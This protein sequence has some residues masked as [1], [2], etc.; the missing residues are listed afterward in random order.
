M[1]APGIFLLTIPRPMIVTSTNAETNVV[2]M[3]PSVGMSFTLSTNFSMVVP[4]CPGTPNI[5]PN[6]PIATWMPTPV[7]N[8]IRTLRERKSA[9]KPNFTIRAMIKM[10]P[11]MMAVH[12]ASATYC[13]DAIGARPASPAAM[14]A[15]LAESA[16]TTR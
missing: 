14:I 4:D 15:A 3:F 7:R 1:S 8:P 13:G 16:P 9:M 10:T 12:P 6:W 5:A 2:G 11:V